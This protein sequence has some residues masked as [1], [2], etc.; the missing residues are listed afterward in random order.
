MEAT[1][2]SIDS[3]MDEQNVVYTYNEILFSLKKQGNFDTGYNM[4]ELWGHC[5][6]WNKPFSERQILYNSNSTL[7]EEYPE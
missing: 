7:Y 2:I 5:T 4:D 3:W 6:K 1:Q